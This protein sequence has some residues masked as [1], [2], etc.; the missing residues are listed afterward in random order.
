MTL[1]VADLSSNNASYDSIIRNNDAAIIKITEGLSYVSPLANAQVATVRKYKKRL[2]LY[3]FIVGGLSA[4]KQAEYFYNNAKGYINQ[5][6][7]VVVLDW[8]KPSGY[9]ALSGNE[10]K[11]FMDRLYELTKKRA[12]LYIGHQDVVSPAFNWSDIKGTYGLWVAGYPSNNGAPYSQALLNWAN[13]NYFSNSK[14]NGQTIAMWQY[15]SVPYDR[16]VFFGDGAAWDRYGSAVGSA[17][18][19]SR[20]AVKENRFAYGD[21]VKLIDA[22]SHSAYGNAFSKY[23]KNA[24]GWVAQEKNIKK[25]RSNYVYVVGFYY[26]GAVRYW[27]VLAQDLKKVK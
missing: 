17:P 21:K 20:P 25:S 18:K 1:Y 22:A 14:Y 4:R 5:K 10:P 26:A 24:T 23:V 12:L 15:D 27:Q 8:E 7:V 16:S 6:N 11:E 13:S 9:P 2:G 3:H 19:P